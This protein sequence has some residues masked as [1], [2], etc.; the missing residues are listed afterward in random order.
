MVHAF[1]IY[2]AEGALE[3]AYTGGAA[4]PAPAVLWWQGLTPAW[5][6]PRAVAQHALACAGQRVLADAALSLACSSAFR[7]SVATPRPASSQAQTQTAASQAGAAAPARSGVG[8]TAANPA[9]AAAA[10]AA[11]LS[12]APEGCLRATVRADAAPGPVESHAAE[13]A[14]A[15]AAAAQGGAALWALPRTARVLWRFVPALTAVACLVLEDT[16]TLAAAQHALAALVA[17]LCEHPSSSPFSSHSSSSSSSSPSSSLRSGNSSTSS[18]GADGALGSSTGVS[19]A[20]ATA[21]RR[22]LFEQRPEETV[23]LVD[24]LLPGGQLLVMP[25]AFQTK[26]RR[27]AAVLASSKT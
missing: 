6:V 2:G 16:D 12:A 1:V 11:V 21:R 14:A 23:A 24:H 13:A 8:S 18:N 17:A 3:G 9:A 15:A 25:R 10:G 22:E 4:V 5:N 20:A 27:D 7:A 26:L 19:T